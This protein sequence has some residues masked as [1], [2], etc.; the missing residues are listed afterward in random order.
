[1]EV[2]RGRVEDYD[3]LRSQHA[4]ILTE[5]RY[6]AARCGRSDRAAAFAMELPDDTTLAR[7]VPL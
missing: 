2:C 7:P 5:S 3:K 1:V 4:A 6:E